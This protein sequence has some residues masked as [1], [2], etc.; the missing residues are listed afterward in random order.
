MLQ[1]S[2]ASVDILSVSPGGSRDFR[3]ATGLIMPLPRLLI[4]I[5]PALLFGTSCTDSPDIPNNVAPDATVES[6]P[7]S[8]PVSGSQDEALISPDN[9]LPEQFGRLSAQ[10][11]GDL[12]GMTERRMIRTLVVSGG[13]QF[14]FYNG[15]PRGI[16]AELLVLLQ[17]EINQGLDRRLDQ[18]E[19][20]PVP[21]SRDRM[22]P[23][24]L[25]GHA[26][27]IAAD[28]TVT[29][30]RSEL[31]DF[32]IPLVTDID[33]I[34]V[35]APGMG[36]GVDTLDDLSGRSIYVR[37]S[38]SYFEHL[39]ALN[40]ELAERG[41]DPVQ[42]EQA[43][44]FLRPQDI[45]EMVNAGLVS[46]TI[47]DSYK[48]SYW[49]ELLT[50]ME[51]RNDLVVHEGGQIAWAFRKNSPNLAAVVN[52]FGRGH[53]QGTLVGNV[54]INRYME[55]L[56]WIRNATS[57]SGFARLQPLLALFEA[58]GAESNIDPLMLAAQAYQESEL[59]HSKKSPAGAVGIMQVKPSTAA[60]RNVGISDISTPAA[61]ISA[62][63]RYMRFLMD[64]YFS[65]PG[66]DE[67]QSWLFALAAYNAGPA[68]IQGLRRQA[69]A[70]GHDPNVWIENVELIAARK[71]GRETVRYVRNIF[72]YYVAYR[73]AI[74]A[75]ELRQSAI[76][77]Q[78]R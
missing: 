16:V 67:K 7:P 33:E 58:S 17:A 39:S 15:K 26:D 3:V 29:D 24:L 48:A 23:A 43:D 66:M 4:F 38:S 5:L 77:V 1:L 45:L 54:L 56:A 75:A 46:A 68:R 19:I 6:A 35:F 51:V 11:T 70:E 2:I 64:R 72:K 61:N 9:L 55:N 31:V 40:D 36:D 71:I 63:A 62:G 73:L 60:D 65:D 50:D 25:S 21:V 76:D 10:W 59:D 34:L 20:V 41:L 28:L 27:L 14:F 12:D 52:Q 53:R 22:I 32:S 44:E 57:E 42:I 69:A 13:P 30:A 47:I 8:S 37:S 74:E 18:V 49:S 78:I